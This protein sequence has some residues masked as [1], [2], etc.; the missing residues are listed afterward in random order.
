MEEKGRRDG[1][2]GGR[3]EGGR[4]GRGGREREERRKEEKG[5]KKVG[6]KGRGEKFSD[7]ITSSL[8]YIISMYVYAGFRVLV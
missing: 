1:G 4:E 8:L 2:R 6:M 5:R 3:R 7:S